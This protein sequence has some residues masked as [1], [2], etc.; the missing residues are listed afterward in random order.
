MIRHKQQSSLD[1]RFVQKKLEEFFKED[2]IENDIT[3][4]ATQQELQSI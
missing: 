1:P 3:T 2:N 4:K